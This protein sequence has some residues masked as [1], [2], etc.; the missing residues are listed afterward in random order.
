MCNILSIF[1]HSFCPL[2]VLLRFLLFQAGFLS[3]GVVAS[4]E[5]MVPWLWFHPAFLALL[6]R[7]IWHEALRKGIL[8]RLWTPPAMEGSFDTVNLQLAAPL[9][10]QDN[11]QRPMLLKQYAKALNTGFTAV[12]VVRAA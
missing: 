8:N 10:A 11:K 5:C 6:G 2:I 7:R 1:Q 4:A 9:P 12:R 3:S